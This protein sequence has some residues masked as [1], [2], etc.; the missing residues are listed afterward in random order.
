MEKKSP[1]NPSQTVT[2]NLVITA[3]GKDRPG[4]INELSRIVLE[5]K[6]NVVDSRMTVL[7]GEFAILLLVSGKWDTIARLEAT[8]PKFQEKL[9]LTILTKRTSDRPIKH[10]HLP[11][12]VEVISIDHPGIVYKVADFFSSRQINVEEMNTSSHHAPHTGTPMFVLNMV[13]GVPR[14][15]SIT[16]LRENFLDFCDSQNL[17]GMLEPIK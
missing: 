11:Y 4:I 7:G 15:E 2:D 13:L 3:I 1:T 16:Q 10:E 12:H 6:G 17:D 5:Q 9:E 8:L 14:K